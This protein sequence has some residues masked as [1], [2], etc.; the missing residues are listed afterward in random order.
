MKRMKIFFCFVLLIITSFSFS[1]EIKLEEKSIDFSGVSRNAICV[2]IP[3]TTS[4]FIEKKIKDEMKD[5]GGKYNSSK[6]EFLTTQSQ[7]KE[8]GEKLFDGYAKIISAKDGIIVVAFGFDLGGAFLSSSAHK[9]QYTSISNR[10]KAF[11]VHAAKEATE[12][13]IKAQEKL[14]HTVEKEQETLEKDKAS[15]EKEI[16]EAK[17]RIEEAQKKIEQNK[18]DQTKKKEEI[19]NQ[20]FKVQEVTKKLSAIK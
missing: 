9:E 18:Q 11:A 15:L 10:I 2:T 14:L 6:G 13:E 7:I 3:Y 20:S 5:W 17:K 19:K 1:Q 12:E 16:E 4:D 8:I